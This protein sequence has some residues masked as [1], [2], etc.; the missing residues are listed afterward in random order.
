MYYAQLIRF[1]FDGPAEI[2]YWKFPKKHV[3]D[4]VCAAKPAMY[5]CKKPSK[6]IP[7]NCYSHCED[8]GTFI[9]LIER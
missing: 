9:R 5:P 7:V 6:E 8:H 1:S 4:N 3:R 2:E